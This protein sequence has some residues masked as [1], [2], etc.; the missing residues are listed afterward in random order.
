M[1]VL[2]KNSENP[3][4]FPM[5][6]VRSQTKYGPA[7]CSAVRTL[8]GYKQTNRQAKYICIDNNVNKSVLSRFSSENGKSFAKILHFSQTFFSA[9]FTKFRFNLFRDTM[10]K[11]R[12]K[13]KCENF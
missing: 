13:N 6:H 12:Q 2:R 8:I 1:F 10:R 3:R 9:F 7:I 11:F 5:G 4:N